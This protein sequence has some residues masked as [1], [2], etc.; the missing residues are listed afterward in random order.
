MPSKDGIE[1]RNDRKFA[2]QLAII[3]APNNPAKQNENKLCQKISVLD[4]IFALHYFQAN[5]RMPNR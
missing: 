4:K 1:R 5:T 2:P 3:S